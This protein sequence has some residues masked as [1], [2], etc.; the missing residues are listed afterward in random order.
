MERAIPRYLWV[1]NSLKNQIETEDFKVGDFLPPEPELQKTFHVSRTTVRKAVEMLA[2]QGFVYIRQGKGTQVM[3]FKATQKLG[4]VTSFSET[5]REKGATVTQG[6]VRIDFV[7][8]PCRIALDLQIEPN[9]RLVKIERVTLANGT[10]IALMTNYLLP[11][12]APGIEKRIGVMSSLYS[13][14]ES[15]YNLV[16]EAATDF[17]S[18]RDVTEIEAEKLQIPE[19]SPLLVVRRITHSGGRPIEVAILLVVADKYEYCVHTKDRPPR[20]AEQPGARA[21]AAAGSATE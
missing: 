3:D 7:P 2:Q 8:A 1:H 4:F 9:E 16:I 5:L 17:I 20:A 21:A 10:P 19:H 12:I 11:S 15:E 14:L 13:F 18:A 6:D